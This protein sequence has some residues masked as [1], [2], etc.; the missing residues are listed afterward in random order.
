[1]TSQGWERSSQGGNISEDAQ[2]SDAIT[3]WNPACWYVGISA[4][5][6]IMKCFRAIPHSPSISH[7]SYK[8]LGSAEFRIKGKHQKLLCIFSVAVLQK[9]LWWDVGSSWDTQIDRLQKDTEIKFRSVLNLS[10]FVSL[11]PVTRV[12]WLDLSGRGG[13]PFFQ[14]MSMK[15]TFRI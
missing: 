7:Q 12:T 5:P 6:E 1:M 4:P 15:N 13:R 11:G 9:A 3:L 14:A 10:V 2:R 8:S